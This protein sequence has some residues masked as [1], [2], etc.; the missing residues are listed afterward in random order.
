MASSGLGCERIDGHAAAARVRGWVQ[1]RVAVEPLPHL[2]VVQVGRHPASD[3]YIKKKRVACREVGMAFSLHRL[4]GE[5]T[6]A[7]VLAQLAELAADPAIHGVL[8]QLPL[9][10]QVDKPAVLAAIPP[11]KDVDGLHPHNVGLLHAGAPRLVPCTARAVIALLGDPNTGNGL[12]APNL[13]GLHAVVVGRS[14]LVGRPLAQL[15]LDAQATVTV[16]H[17]RTRDLAA[18][19]R[20][21]DIVIAAAGQPGLITGPMVQPGATVIDVGITRA[22]DGT[23]CG[24]V[25]AESVQA[26]AGRLSPVPG[27]VGPMTIAMLLHNVW[28]ARELCSVDE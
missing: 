14:P 12:D 15:L 3:V 22:A 24:D 26:V 18:H 6:T 5:A 1:Q 19:T 16:C 8:V 9:P 17:S 13:S 25:E 28:L 21:A 10:A 2:A 7:C 23:L 20:M 11:H 4:P 27:G